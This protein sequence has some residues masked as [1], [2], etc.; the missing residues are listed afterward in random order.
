MLL[1]WVPNY[2]LSTFLNNYQLHSCLE[3]YFRYHFFYA[4]GKG[5]PETV[6]PPPNVIKTMMNDTNH[7]LQGYNSQGA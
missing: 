1:P 2:Q 5:H 3:I 4:K 7:V 6:P